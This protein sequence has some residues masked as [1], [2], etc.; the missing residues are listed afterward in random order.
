MYETTRH[1]Y[2]SAMGIDSYMPRRLLPNAPL[3][4]QCEWPVLSTAGDLTA[5]S[6]AK[7]GMPPET[8]TALESSPA[9][10]DLAASQVPS[11]A[12]SLQS[13]AASATG[14]G[15]KGAAA[16]LLA[17]LGAIRKNNDHGK[18]KDVKAQ[19]LLSTQTSEALRFSLSV[20]RFDDLLVL[21]SRHSEK[22]L[23][24]EKLLLSMLQAYGL[25]LGNLPKAQV[26]QW[27]MFDMPQA[28]TGVQAAR[29]MLGAF[30][31]TLLDKPLS[32]WWLMGADAF[33]LLPPDILAESGDGFGQVI[34]AE[35][36]AGANVS[37]ASQLITMP[38]LADMLER[39][40][41]KAKAW[42]AMALSC[43]RSNIS[44]RSEQNT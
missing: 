44:M 20:W 22:A 7:K 41:L 33:H 17:D 34:K 1:Q 29:E 14:V 38:S 21:D 36:L 35:Q 4:V 23:P 39:P 28:D 19:A 3:P 37:P 11:A 13:D 16:E 31:D 9:Q 5:E 27:P 32:H 12:T 30:L 18:P 10:D 6:A 24:T 2:L 15:E 40:Q 25:K 43:G 42:Q 26:L 8:Y